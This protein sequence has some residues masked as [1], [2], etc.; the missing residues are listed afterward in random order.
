MNR[1]KL[2]IQGYI[3][4]SDQWMNEYFGEDG[5]FSSEECQAFLAENADATE[6]DVEL[7]SDGGYADMAFDIH[8]QLRNCGKVVHI[9]GYNV[10]SAAVAI[11]LAAEKENRSL[12]KLAPLMIH[13]ATIDPY[14]LGNMNTTQLAALATELK[15]YDEK[16]L[17]LYV[18]RTGSDR[19]VLSK[20][21]ANDKSM[22]A[23]RALELGFCGKILDGQVENKST[24]EGRFVTPMISQFI[25]NNKNT[26]AMTDK[27]HEERLNAF[28][29]ILKNIENRLGGKPK[30]STVKNSEE[31]SLFFD[32]DKIAKDTIL[33]EDE[34]KSKTVEAGTHKVGNETI[35]VGEG[36][37]VSD[38]LEAQADDTEFSQVKDELAQ[39]KAEN[40]RLQQ[41]I[42]ESQNQVENAN[43]ETIK[44]M[45]EMKTEF[46]NLKKDLIGDTG[47]SPKKVE[48][49]SDEK[50]SIAD[51]AA[52]R[53]R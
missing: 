26:T 9:V 2:V 48:N 11:L 6:I 45:G 22:T 13:Q 15:E 50:L 18:E 17:D 21:M 4:P 32:G 16:L 37:V 27:K 30:V 29:R 38:V 5:M 41:L 7:R 25:Q 53:A 51:I 52:K 23:E 3:G 1:P 31:K 20:E 44:L 49:K 47:K 36:G 19:K 12:T 39:T 8:D 43:K 34:A 42:S 35:T 33:Y 14:S 24:S 28:E 40:K 10:K 46:E